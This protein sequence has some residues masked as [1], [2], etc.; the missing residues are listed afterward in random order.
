MTKTRA[1]PSTIKTNAK[2]S[3][4]KSVKQQSLRYQDLK[5]DVGPHR[6]ARARV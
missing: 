6:P 4:T 1:K 5:P 3:I 2:R